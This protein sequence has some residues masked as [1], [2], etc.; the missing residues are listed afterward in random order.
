MTEEQ[1][2]SCSNPQPMLECR[3]QGKSSDRKA[4]LFAGVA[5]CRRIWPMF[6]DDRSR[7]AVEAA[8]AYAEG[9]IEKQALKACWDAE[10]VTTVGHAVDGVTAADAV[11]G[12]G[13]AAVNVAEA[14]KEAMAEKRYR[15]DVERMLN[16][17]SRRSFANLEARL[18]KEDRAYR[19]ERQAQCAILRDIVGNPFRTVE[20]DPA[21]RI[22]TIVTLAC[23]TYE[24][25]VPEGTLDRGL[26]LTL[27]ECLA[28]AGCCDAS[29]LE[30]LRGPG[31]HWRGCY[32]LDLI[33]GKA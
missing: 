14:R 1:W 17:L 3:Q 8:E 5:C 21:W 26:V 18:K 6:E 33:L 20:F 28:D 16:G 2:L 22:P 29:L 4:R 12:A 31:P 25:L 11:W 23:S 30:H 9:R 10:G 24:T 13:W 27:G 15:D 7:R 32:A 19:T